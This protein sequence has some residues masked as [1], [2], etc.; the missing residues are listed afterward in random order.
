MVNKVKI[1]IEFFVIILLISP[2]LGQFIGY[3][4]FLSYVETESMQPSMDPNDGFVAIPSYFVGSIENGD[5]IVFKAKKLHGGG[6]TTHRVIGKSENGYLTKGDNNPFIDQ[7]GEE[8]PVK[9]EQIVAEAFQIN[10]ILVVIPNLGDI[11][12]SFRGIV[13]SF[14]SFLASLFGIRSFLGTQGLLYIILALSI[15][16][17]IIDLFLEENTKKRVKE[18]VRNK[19]VDINY[20]VIILTILVVIS[21]TSS[22]LLSSKIHTITVEGKSDISRNSEGLTSENSVSTEMNIPNSGFIPVYVFFN[23]ET[24]NINANPDKLLVGSREIKN[25]SIIIQPPNVDGRF[26]EIISENRYFAILPMFILEPL[27][28]IHSWLPILVIDII[29]GLLF[30]GVSI[31]LLGHGRVRGY[32]KNKKQSIFSKIKSIIKY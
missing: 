16:L 9:R 31:S 10:N 29:I 13:S 17:Y 11:I 12:N 20:L 23:S 2:V 24:E 18:K 22:M 6:L 26:N 7:D 21:A 3:P 4:V 1:L 32:S 25:S 30:Y 8:P 15:L 28:K 5:V 27:Y 14:Q 19:G